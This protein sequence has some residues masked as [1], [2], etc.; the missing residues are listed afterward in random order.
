MRTSFASIKQTIA[1]F[2]ATVLVGSLA[3]TATLVPSPVHAQV[4]T[5]CVN[6]SQIWQ[7]IMEYAQQVETAV[8]TANQLDYQIKSYKDAVTQGRVLPNQVWGNFM[9]DLSRLNDLTRQTRG[10]AY[11]SDTLTSDFERVFPNYEKYLDQP[12][13]PAQAGQMYDQWS[14]ETY[15]AS[16]NAMATAGMQVNQ[17]RDE[18]DVMQQ[19]QAHSTSAAGQMQAMQAGNEIAAQQV[20]QMQKLRE[21]V[22]TNTSLQATAMANQQ[23]EK[24]HLRAVQDAAVTEQAKPFTGAAK[25]Y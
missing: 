5:A 6:C 20:R 3:I 13:T 2:V 17:M 22:A 21:L 25:S 24:D 11:T 12:A 9:S 18:D 23:R 16:R 19:L 4:V 15:D 8:N 14:D 1:S 10:L 7:Q